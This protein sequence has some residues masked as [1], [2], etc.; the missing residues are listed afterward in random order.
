MIWFQNVPEDSSIFQQRYLVRLELLG[1][2]AL[3]ANVLSNLHVVYPS[4]GHGSFQGEDAHYYQSSDEQTMFLSAL[5]VGLWCVSI[6]ACQRKVRLGQSAG[7]GSTSINMRP[8][9]PSK[10]K[11]VQ[12]LEIRTDGPQRY[13]KMAK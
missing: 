12:S 11:I 10:P 4:C 2:V 8:L 5:V 1:N 9:I 7:L 3:A 13:A 6:N